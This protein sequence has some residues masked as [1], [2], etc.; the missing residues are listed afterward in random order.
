MPELEGLVAALPRNGYEW[1]IGEE[2]G[3]LVPIAVTYLIG[4]RNLSGKNPPELTNVDAILESRA[5]KA[6]NIGTLC[7]TS[8]RCESKTNISP[9]DFR[10]RDRRIDDLWR[11]VSGAIRLNNED[12][13]LRVSLAHSDSRVSFTTGAS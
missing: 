3:G 9:G 5:P 8:H 7:D 10:K 6:A 2:R 13:S 12:T 4:Y 11:K 1:K